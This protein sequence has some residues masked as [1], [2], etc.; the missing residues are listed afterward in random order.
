VLPVP[1]HQSHSVASAKC[2]CGNLHDQSQ[3]LRL[4]SSPPA[5]MSS[6]SA[7]FMARPAT[8]PDA[9]KYQA[10]FQYPWGQRQPG[11]RRR[12]C[13]GTDLNMRLTS[14]HKTGRPPWLLLEAGL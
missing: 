2:V 9:T 3:V 10:C 11:T 6:A 1:H 13:S 14:V 8:A 5:F 7:S 4:R 12:A